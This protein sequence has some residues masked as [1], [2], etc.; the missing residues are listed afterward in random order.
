MFFVGYDD[1]SAGN[2]VPG[3]A[4]NPQPPYTITQE[5]LDLGYYDFNVPAK[6]HY[7]VC[8][9]GAVEA[10]VIVKNSFG[11]T[12]GAKKRVFCDVKMPGWEDCNNRP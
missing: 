11:S 6:Y 12:T 7:A 1:L 10:H 2:P 8:T 9:R 4:Y 3:A 5:D